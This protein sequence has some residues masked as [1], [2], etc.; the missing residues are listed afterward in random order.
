MANHGKIVYCPYYIYEQKQ[1]ITCEDTIRRHNTPEAKR[2]WMTMY[3]KSKRGWDKCPYAKGLNEIYE[4]TERMSPR[5]G[6]K[7]YLKYINE[8]QRAELNKLLSAL[9][10]AE[11]KLR[12]GGK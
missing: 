4:Q 9:G 11:S 2:N 5:E 1:S 7:L 3:C 8:A 12:R 10:A 6:E